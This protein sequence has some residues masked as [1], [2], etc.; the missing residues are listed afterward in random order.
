[1]GQIIKLVCICQSLCQCICPS[2]STRH[3][4]ICGN[5]VISCMC[6]APG[7]NYRNSSF[8]VDVAMW[9]IHVLQ[10]IFLV[11]K[12]T[13]D[14]MTGVTWQELLFMW[15]LFV[16]TVYIGRICTAVPPS[17]TT[18]YWSLLRFIIDW[19]V[20]TAA[21]FNATSCIFWSCIT[22]CHTPF[23]FYINFIL[24]ICMYKM[25][26]FTYGIII[27]IIIIINENE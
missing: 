4:C 27:I 21:E 20:Q 7:D 12:Q 10:N 19:T 6:H 1:M 8:I 24:F 18:I 16:W 3:G 14:K 2:A 9:Q 11:A 13:W 15:R 17:E 5:T 25:C 26:L 23:I 22:H